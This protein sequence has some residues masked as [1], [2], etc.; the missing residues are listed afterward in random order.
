V[1]SASNCNMTIGP[2]GLF[3]K[4]GT[5][6]I[7]VWMPATRAEHNRSGLR[8]Q[9]DLIDAEWALI[10]EVMPAPAQRQPAPSLMLSPVVQEMAALAQW[11]GSS[12]PKL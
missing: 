11:T 3:L 1:V 7:V 10:A 12:I 8:Y 6:E 4:I 9:T 5:L 2:V